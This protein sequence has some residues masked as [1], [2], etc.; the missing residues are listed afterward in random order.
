MARSNGFD[1]ELQYVKRRKMLHLT[2][3]KD[4]YGTWQVSQTSLQEVL[5]VVTDGK[6]KPLPV[7][8]VTK[9]PQQA[10]I[11]TSTKT[12]KKN[13]ETGFPVWIKANVD[14]KLTDVIKNSQDSK[15][16]IAFEALNVGYSTLFL[17]G[18]KVRFKEITS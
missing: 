9:T 14:V 10:K 3:G 15:L 18:E 2:K 7:E 4:Q 8:K 6:A 1:I 5:Q 16:G 11:A 12:P 13:I 17:S